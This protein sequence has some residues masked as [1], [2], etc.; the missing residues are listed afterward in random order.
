MQKV[1]LFKKLRKRKLKSIC[2]DQIQVNLGTLGTLNDK[3]IYCKDTEN[4]NSVGSILT[5]VVN[6]RVN[7]ERKT[8]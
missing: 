2:D 1:F 6:Q 7:Q 3:I 8:M 4:K 5:H